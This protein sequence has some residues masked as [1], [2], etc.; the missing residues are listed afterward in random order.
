LQ[1]FETI[2]FGLGEPGSIYGDARSLVTLSPQT[3]NDVN[4]P[5]FSG[6]VNAALASG[7]LPNNMDYNGTGAPFHYGGET[8][9]NLLFSN[10]GVSLATPTFQDAFHPEMF[11]YQTWDVVRVTESISVRRVYY[12]YGTAS[13]SAGSPVTFVSTTDIGNNIVN[14][15]NNETD[16]LV[17]SDPTNINANFVSLPG[18]GDLTASP[19][20]W[21]NFSGAQTTNAVPIQTWGN[22]ANRGI[23]KRIKHCC[24]VPAKTSMTIF[25]KKATFAWSPFLRSQGN[26]AF[27]GTNLAAFPINTFLTDLCQGT[28]GNAS[29]NTATSS[30]AQM[31]VDMM[32]NARGIGNLYIMPVLPASFVAMQYVVDAA[33]GA[34]VSLGAKVVRMYIDYEFSTS[35]TVRCRDYTNMPVP[36]ATG[37]P[38]LT[39]PTL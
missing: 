3:E 15:R 23:V 4:A 21:T 22:L 5:N 27:T 9:S 18:D 38:S 36:L 10:P 7:L 34:P 25:P 2:N 8:W 31:P 28:P 19:S 35:V 11:Q 12:L 32:N 14:E 37:F 29:L 30:G 39:F 20:F 17:W 24:N 13:G 6:G 33:A 1:A 16:F 26:A